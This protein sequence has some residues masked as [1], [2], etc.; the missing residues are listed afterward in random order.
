MSEPS[1]A[2]EEVS[3]H[4]RSRAGDL[5]PITVQVEQFQ[6][7]PARERATVEPNAAQQLAFQFTPARERAT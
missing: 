7:T 4:A 5:G 6:F 1:R 2:R 3:I